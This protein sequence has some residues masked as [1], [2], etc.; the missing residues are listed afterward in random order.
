VALEDLFSEK[1]E[2]PPAGHKSRL[3][4][5]AQF[6]RLFEG[7]V[8]TLRAWIREVRQ[9][10][11]AIKEFV[12]YPAPEVAARTLSS[13]LFGEDAI[14][15]SREQPEAI[16]QLMEVNQIHALNLEGGVTCAVEGEIYYKIDWDEQIS[17]R[18]IISIF[19]G[20]QAFPV[21]RF[22]RLV[23]IAFVETW[24]GDQEGDPVWRHVELRTRGVIRHLLFKGS[25]EG[26]GTPQDLSDHSSTE[27]LQEEVST[28]VADLLVRHVPFWRT[29]KSSHG[30]SVYR[31][32]EGLIAALHALYSQ[33]QH[34]A[35]MAKRRIAMA[36]TYLKR[37]E[38]GEIKFDRDLDV[39]ALSEDAAGAIG[40]ESKPI[41]Q[42]EF[43]DSTTMGDRI[44]QRLDEFLLACGIAPESAGRD[45]AGAA[46]SGTAR[47]LAQ[48]LTLATVAAAGRYFKPALKAAMDLGSLVTA[49]HLDETFPIWSDTSIELQDGLPEDQVE[50]AQ[51]VGQLRGAQAMSIWQAVT[52][53]HPDWDEVEVQIEVARIVEEQGPAVPDMFEGGEV[54]EVPGGGENAEEELRPA[55]V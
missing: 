34:D 12:P 18:A 13:F 20:S 5:A 8:L 55:K 23:E 42:I 1:R 16:L 19:P 24:E 4:Q 29:S 47:K 35:E 52:E 41:H 38:E 46:H 51:R 39:F 6:N 22:G 11:K 17:P 27:G 25:S 9:R 37:D 45:V 36:E 43:T 30:I 32:K 2:W 28:Q 49:L 44:A 53:Q 7:N 48:S 14:I 3:A 26:L 21:F 15:K 54:P 50:Q 33:D 31:G 40:A 10:D